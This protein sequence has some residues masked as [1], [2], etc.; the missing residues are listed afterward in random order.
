MTLAKLIDSITPEA[1]RVPGDPT[2]LYEGLTTLWNQE[3]AQEAG[4]DIDF[5][6]PKQRL[7]WKPTLKQGDV[8]RE[9][10]DKFGGPSK[11]PGILLLLMVACEKQDF[12]GYDD[13]WKLWG[14]DML[15]YQIGWIAKYME[16]FHP[17][18][19]KTAEFLNTWAIEIY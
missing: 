15:H 9:W 2:I 14:S 17:D 19:L 11:G 4:P 13:E 8:W 12:P 16:T 7:D 1:A 10:C 6:I 18:F 3:L 5:I